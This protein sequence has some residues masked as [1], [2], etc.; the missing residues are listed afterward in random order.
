MTSAASL[1]QELEPNSIYYDRHS[2]IDSLINMTR[3]L[4]RGVQRPFEGIHYSLCWKSLLLYKRG[5]IEGV[6]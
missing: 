5:T 2:G 3:S 1:Y 6:L 4:S